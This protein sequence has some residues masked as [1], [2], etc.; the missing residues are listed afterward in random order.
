MS[1]KA[2]RSIRPS[3][4]DADAVFAGMQGYRAPEGGFFLWLPVTDG[5]EAALKLW[6]ETGVRVLPGAYLARDVGGD[7]PGQGIHPRGAGRR[8]DERGAGCSG[9]AT[10]FTGKGKG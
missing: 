8:R 2:A 10:V 5:E 7:N 1:P 6:R 4:R 9:C 3:S